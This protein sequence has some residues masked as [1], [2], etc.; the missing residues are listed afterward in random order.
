MFQFIIF[1]YFTNKSIITNTMKCTFSS[2]FDF[3]DGHRE[4]DQVAVLRMG[5]GSV[6]QHLNPPPFQAVSLSSCEGF[7]RGFVPP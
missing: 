6:Q 5:R 4:R 3:V 1:Q 7:R 2:F